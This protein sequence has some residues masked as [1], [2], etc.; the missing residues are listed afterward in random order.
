MFQHPRLALGVL[1]ASAVLASTPARAQGPPLTRDAAGVTIRAARIDAPLRIDGKLDEA[2]YATLPSING[3]I[4][5]DPNPGAPSTERTDVWVLFDND[6]VYVAARCWDDHPE[7]IIANEMRRD[8]GN[9]IQNDFLGFGLDTF[10]DHRNGTTFVVNAAGGKMDGQIT[11][12]RIYNGDVN[13]VWDAKVGRFDGGW[14]MEASVPFK[15]LRYRP[16]AEQVWGILLRR[17][18]RWKSEVTNITPIP[19]AKAQNGLITYSY[20]AK[21][22]G[23]QAPQH[24][25]GLEVKPFALGSLTTDKA[26]HVDNAL[27]GSVGGDLKYGVTQNI[28]ADFTYNTDFA[29][30][31]A[32]DQQINLTRFN[33]FFPEKREFFL[34]N[35]GM[36]AFA[37]SGS[38]GG[39]NADVP[40]VFYSRRIG[41]NGAV[42]VPIQVGGRL[43]GRMGLFSLGVLNIETKADTASRTPATNFTVVRAKRNVLRRSAIGAV[44][45]DRS[46]GQFIAGR[47]TA[48]GLDAT[49]S[50]FDY[51]NLNGYWAHAASSRQ[52]DGDQESYRGQL[53][54][55]ADRYGLQVERLVVGRG[56]NPDLGFVRRT[57]I[58]ETFGQFRF[59]PRP[60]HSKRIRRYVWRTS[61]LQAETGAGRVDTRTADAEFDIEFHNSDRFA[62]QPSLTH[63]FLPQPFR[64]ASG[65]TLPV[66][67]YDYANLRVSYSLGQQKK[68]AGTI[69]LDRGTFY[70]GDRTVLTLSSGRVEVTPRFSLQPTFSL[71]WV[72]LKEGDFQSRLVGGRVTYTVTPLMFVSALVQYNS[73]TTSLSSNVRLRWEYRPGSEIFVVYN[74]QRD[75][76]ASGFPDLANRA[77][78]VK[79]NKL[80]RF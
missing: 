57:D 39:T 20:E 29:Q 78:I 8:N 58:R 42:T 22:V 77:F 62:I 38:V 48:Y 15:S 12:E 67:A 31:E 75:T 40:T 51:L 4:Q 64:I 79:V 52:A 33:L 30:V 73:S 16:D 5:A 9:I 65:V 43:T 55:A 27:D 69:A 6:N 70:D 1:A 13:P 59:S 49:F 26:S 11:D 56:F 28:T 36:F 35:Q 23:I 10:F 61:V 41:L 50:F 46:T 25:H 80:I 72:N 14:T 34:E 68:R 2:V 3:F 54:Y 32:D 21:L 18:I 17:D 44:Y 19:Q 47:N 60:A 37:G 24:G 76:R 7:R 66:G 63:E 71:N 74:D 53:D 45:T